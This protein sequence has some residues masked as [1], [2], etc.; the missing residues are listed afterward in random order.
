MTQDFKDGDV[1]RVV[2]VWDGDRHYNINKGDMGVIYALH[3]DGK[4]WLIRW[5]AHGD[6]D[7]SMSPM[8]LEKVDGEV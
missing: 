6:P 5:F 2:D 4:D 3:S 1:V 8:Q 7:R